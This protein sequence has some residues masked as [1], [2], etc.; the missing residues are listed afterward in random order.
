MT[1][2]RFT[3][4]FNN[5]SNELIRKPKD[6]ASSNDFVNR[7]ES[8]AKTICKREPMIEDYIRLAQLANYKAM[9]W[10]L[11]LLTLSK[12]TLVSKAKE[13]SMKGDRL[14][15][16]KPNYKFM[17]MTPLANLNGY[18]RKHLASCMDMELGYIN[19]TEKLVIEKYG[20]VFNYCVLA[21]AL[22][23]ED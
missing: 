1:P 21:I 7:F 2:E 9:E 17:A 8:V 12:D 20:D 11:D 3:E 14:W 5:V 19:P 13:Y 16:F 4:L 15:N 22:L 6:I 18:L 23:S 10:S